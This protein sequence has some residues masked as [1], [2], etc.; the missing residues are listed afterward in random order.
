ML[1][2]QRE[3][4]GADG[5]KIS[6][7]SGDDRVPI[8]EHGNSKKR[9]IAIVQSVPGGLYLIS[10]TLR[11]CFLQ[12]WKAESQEPIL[13]GRL[14]G[15][16]LETSFDLG[17]V[18]DAVP[19]I[20]HNKEA[21]Y[22]GTPKR[23]ACTYT[24]EQDAPAGSPC[25]TFTPTQRQAAAMPPRDSQPSLCEPASTWSSLSRKG[26]E[27][28]F[29]TDD[30]QTVVHG[31]CEYSDILQD[32]P[33]SP[34][35]EV[36]DFLK[37][38]RSQSRRLLQ[39]IHRFLSGD[40]SGGALKECK[41]IELGHLQLACAQQT[42]AL[43]D[44]WEDVWE[45]VARLTDEPAP[46][47]YI[48]VLGG[49]GAG[50]SS[51]LNCLLGESALLPTSGCRACTASVVEMA[52]QDISH[53]VAE[54]VFAS[55]A[56]WAEEVRG[57]VQAL[58]DADVIS[59]HRTLSA[60]PSLAKLEA[61]FGAQR[62][63]NVLTDVLP[64]Q[65]AEEL[66]GEPSAPDHL[67]GRLF[68]GMM[69]LASPA[70]AYLGKTVVVRAA[71]AEALSVELARY[72]V[73]GMQHGAESRE[74]WPLVRVVRVKHR[75]AL[76]AD[77][78][79]LVDLPGVQDAN[80]ARGA[81]ALAYKDRCHAVWI[82]ADIARAVDDGAAQDLLASAVKA[83]GEAGAGDRFGHIAFVCTKTDTLD[84]EEILRSFPLGGAAR[85]EA[86]KGA[87]VA[88]AELEAATV[89]L[90]ELEAQQEAC[91]AAEAL[92]VQAGMDREAPVFEGTRRQLALVQP[93]RELAL[94]Q[95]RGLC[96][97]LRNAWC[98]AQLR[99]RCVAADAPRPQGELAV[100][101]VSSQEMQKLEGR[102]GA[103]GLPETFKAPRHTDIPQLRGLVAELSDRRA[104]HLARSK[105]RE[106]GDFLREVREGVLR[107]NEAAARLAAGSVPALN[108]TLTSLFLQFAAVPPT[109]VRQLRNR[110]RE[111]FAGGDGE[112][113]GEEDGDPWARESS[114]VWNL[115][116]L[117][118]RDRE[119]EEADAEDERRLVERLVRHFGACLGEVVAGAQGGG[120]RAVLQAEFADIA[121]HTPALHL[122]ARLQT[123]MTRQLEAR[124]ASLRLA[125]A[126][127]T[128]TRRSLRVE[129][130]RTAA[131]ADSVMH[132]APREGGSSPSDWPL[133]DRSWASDHASSGHGGRAQLRQLPPVHTD[134]VLEAFGAEL[135]RACRELMHVAV[136]Q[137][138]RFHASQ[139]ADPASVAARQVAAKGLDSLHERYERLCSEWS[140]DGEAAGREPP[141]NT[142]EPTPPASPSP[143]PEPVSEACR[144]RPLPGSIAF[145]RDRAL[146][147][148]APALYPALDVAAEVAASRAKKRRRP[149]D[150]SGDEPGP[151]DGEACAPEAQRRRATVADVERAARPSRGPTL[152][153]A[154]PRAGVELPAVSASMRSVRWK[155]VATQSEALQV[156]H[157]SVVGGLALGG[158]TRG[159]VRF[160]DGAMLQMDTPAVPASSV[161]ADAG[162]EAAALLP[163]HPPPETS[164]T[165]FACSCRAAPFS[166]PGARGGEE[167]VAPARPPLCGHALALA[168]VLID[169]SKRSRGLSERLVELRASQHAF[170]SGAAAMMEDPTVGTDRE[171]AAGVAGRIQEAARV[172]R[173]GAL[174][175]SDKLA[176]KGG[177]LLNEPR[178]PCNPPRQHTPK[179]MAVVEAP[180][181]LRFL[182][183]G[184]GASFFHPEV[185]ALL[186]ASRG[187][188]QDVFDA[189]LAV[190]HLARLHAEDL[191]MLLLS[192]CLGFN[193]W[194]RHQGLLRSAVDLISS[195]AAGQAE[196]APSAPQPEEEE[197]EDVGGASGGA[198][199]SQAHPRLLSDAAQRPKQPAAAAAEGL[200]EESFATGGWGLNELWGTPA[201]LHSLCFRPADLDALQVLQEASSEPQ[202][203]MADGHDAKLL[204]RTPMVY[205]GGCVV[206]LVVDETSPDKESAQRLVTLLVQDPLTGELALRG[207]CHPAAAL[208]CGNL[209]E[210]QPR[211]CCGTEHGAP[212]LCRHQLAVLTQLCVGGGT[213][214]ALL[215]PPPV[216]LHG[217]RL[218]WALAQLPAETL[219]AEIL[220]VAQQEH[221]ETALQRLL[222]GGAESRRGAPWGV[223]AG[224]ITASL[225]QLP[226]VD[227]VQGV[228]GAHH[229]Q[230]A[231]RRLEAAM[232]AAQ[233][234]ATWQREFRDHLPCPHTLVEQTCSCKQAGR[235]C[236][237][238]AD[239][240]P[241]FM[242][243]A[244]AEYGRGVKLVR[245][246]QWLMATAASA[247]L[248]GGSTS[249]SRSLG[250][251]LLQHHVLAMR[252]GRR[253]MQVT[254]DHADMKHGVPEECFP[255]FHEGRPVGPSPSLSVPAL[256]EEEEEG[257][258]CSSDLEL[259]VEATLPLL[260]GA[261]VEEE[262][263]EEEREAGT[264]LI[265]DERRM[266]QMEGGNHVDALLEACLSVLTFA[267][268][269]RTAVR[270]PP[271]WDLLEPLTLE[272]CRGIDTDI[273]AHED[274]RAV[275]INAMAA[276]LRGCIV[277]LEAGGRWAAS[278]KVRAELC[279]LCMRR[280]TLPQ[281]KELF[282]GL[283][284][285][286]ARATREAAPL[287][288]LAALL[289]KNLDRLTS[290][291]PN[292]AGD[293][294][295][296]EPL[297]EDTDAGS[298]D[299]QTGAPTRPPRMSTEMYIKQLRHSMDWLTHLGDVLTSLLDQDGGK[300]LWR[301]AYTGARSTL[302]CMAALDNDDVAWSE[303]EFSRICKLMC[304]AWSLGDC[305]GAPDLIR[306][307]LRNFGHLIQGGLVSQSGNDNVEAVRIPAIR[308]A[309]F[310]AVA[311]VT[312]NGKGEIV[313][314]SL[315]T[316]PVWRC[317]ANYGFD[318]AP[319]VT[320]LLAGFVE[321]L[322]SGGH[323][324]AA[325]ALLLRVFAPGRSDYENWVDLCEMESEHGVLQ[326]VKAGGAEQQIKAVL[327]LAH[328]L[329]CCMKSER[330]CMK[331]RPCVLKLISATVRNSPNSTLAAS[332]ALANAAE[333]LLREAL[334]SELRHLRAPSKTARRIRI[335]GSL[336]RTSERSAL[337]RSAK[338]LRVAATRSDS[339]V[340]R[341]LQH[342]CARLELKLMDASMAT[343]EKRKVLAI[344]YATS[345]HAAACVL[346]L[347]RRA[348]AVNEIFDHLCSRLSPPTT[349]CAK[350]L[351]TLQTQ[352]AVQA[353]EFCKDTVAQLAAE[354]QML[355]SATAAAEEEWRERWNASLKPLD[356][357][358][359]HTSHR[360]EWT[361][362][363]CSKCRKMWSSMKAPLQK[364]QEHTLKHHLKAT[365]D[366]EIQKPCKRY[367]SAQTLMHM[368]KKYYWGS[369]VQG[370]FTYI[371]AIPK[372]FD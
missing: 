213:G 100:F 182:V 2:V 314:D 70:T 145:V 202:D 313:I 255:E 110:T 20:P 57:A 36:V 4:D 268:N 43:L 316:T 129:R 119:F 325:F 280:S 14:K 231:V 230:P 324:A 103:E 194:D 229:P 143:Q 126:R 222:R 243:R 62:V 250:A 246:A 86:C 147:A 256:E 26:K 184:A 5:A 219:S 323:P 31:T 211:T 56:E 235:E 215:R 299:A 161:G 76:L 352:R 170:L 335:R 134:G 66:Q 44:K 23:S 101:T 339:M 271:L 60:S 234:R 361:L 327:H 135:A 113:E 140:A 366:S 92:C 82:A 320:E 155:E 364:L 203:A 257:R 348:A 177:A 294:P 79:V 360:G 124:A 112:G 220:R 125:L 287:R 278:C 267:R 22:V 223:A 371:Q 301:C 141:P 247:G 365:F 99:R 85:V 285:A 139:A 45:S 108:A 286:A 338:E 102:G 78:A 372:T 132:E 144:T 205:L 330:R 341:H 32:M 272:H 288:L 305:G 204:V 188:P 142:S 13:L 122:A 59:Y 282:S 329:E 153:G 160:T 354:V 331:S 269:N 260:Y 262:E 77:G 225:A 106:L 321:R 12:L 91:L 19:C 273:D 35:Y 207:G 187:R 302:E 336:D 9:K 123:A 164:T 351:Q 248:F 84:V 218:V 186:A 6:L 275:V 11:G 67:A 258:L 27:S 68:D 326:A 152:F 198:S 97:R 276:A 127:C 357:N 10:A 61:V 18:L 90:K 181:A 298:M 226:L 233:R 251:H 136:Q 138:A 289:E 49:T 306:E 311:A 166:A 51:M 279:V 315:L 55:S 214:G 96:A 236:R 259:L 21:L 228:Y 189:D 242:A 165:R 291:L 358:T 158:R 249:A 328:Q 240:R 332:E 114:K 295:G 159:V 178:G 98:K 296:V 283:V 47:T 34:A 46:Q 65:L 104:R 131:A 150:P 367:P 172:A 266:L 369:K 244:G 185:L 265:V 239:Q 105:L 151:S 28:E 356:S 359:C 297:D 206:A 208:T 8:F 24:L 190:E 73:S 137:C 120:W 238:T 118:V 293:P 37:G 109:S 333:L 290:R 193:Q 195:T 71:D 173:D 347:H 303:E 274:A 72:T 281:E 254:Y 115:V 221:L 128:E 162:L 200:L 33:L 93:Q 87:G 107:D 319:C 69:G 300:E 117:G 318:G 212:H 156:E 252:S 201:V 196:C 15:C 350:L 216:V 50:K 245:T 368:I 217:A 261:A 7:C 88:E 345:L 42:Q 167:V 322:V 270:A 304:Q 52:Y 53:Y 171:H 95:L 16:V 179:A 25:S 264:K 149:S 284:R 308:S 174:T 349:H 192:F 29:D 157:G 64:E 30:I 1:L 237:F 263:E 74:L 40:A 75:W 199:P 312:A 111:L 317:L 116:L 344:A 340:I 133:H 337:V 309:L 94:R 54:I 48:G 121:G 163:P 224:R 154:A 197:M 277:N 180:G 210:V 183:D 130:A 353:C 362:L 346:N 83:R 17:D 41:G 39:P 169:D 176:I 58:A 241:A 175:R 3:V 63:K 89:R 307:L 146:L 342:P 80:S 310:D 148:A 232:R 168:G 209:D 343:D 334:Q 38:F 363:Q 292:A 227:T 355:V 81:A 370:S 253:E 191:A